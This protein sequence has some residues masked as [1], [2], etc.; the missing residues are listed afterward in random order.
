LISKPSSVSDRWLAGN[1]VTDDQA[2]ET[3]AQAEAEAAQE[4]ASLRRAAQTV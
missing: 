3:E 2:A 1:D 4:E